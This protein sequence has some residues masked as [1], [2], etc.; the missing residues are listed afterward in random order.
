MKSVGILCPEHVSALVT[1][2]ISMSLFPHISK[3]FI[4]G[5]QV[6]QLKHIEDKEIVS[7]KGLILVCVKIHSGAAA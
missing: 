4:P 2:G 6:I 7:I 3:Y 5:L 1:S